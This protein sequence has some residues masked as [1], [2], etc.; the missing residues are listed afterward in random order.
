[1][2]TSTAHAPGPGIGARVKSLR[3]SKGLSQ[4][5]LADAVGMHRED[6]VRLETG[7]RSSNPSLT[8]LLAFA[9]ALGVSVS[10]LVP[11]RKSRAA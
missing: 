1:M 11:K 9:E 7:S 3:E 5:A 8:R 2:K 4:S 10:D 6:L